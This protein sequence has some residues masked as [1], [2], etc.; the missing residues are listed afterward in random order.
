MQFSLSYFTDLVSKVK[1]IFYLGSQ[2]QWVLSTQVTG[3]RS[4]NPVSIADRDK[5]FFYSQHPERLWSP[6][7]RPQGHFPLGW[8]G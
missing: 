7:S 1:R 4:S 3:W 6:S 5:I 8:S 2:D